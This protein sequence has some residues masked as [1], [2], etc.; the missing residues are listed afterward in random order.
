MT[1]LVVWRRLILQ[2]SCPQN[3]V[4]RKMTRLVVW[5]RIFLLPSRLQNSVLRKESLIAR[6]IST[7]TH[8][9]LTLSRSSRSLAFSLSLP[10]ALLVFHPLLSCIFLQTG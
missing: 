7:L 6:H 8:Y 9:F 2:P 1:R 10:H 3:S 5:R 4:L